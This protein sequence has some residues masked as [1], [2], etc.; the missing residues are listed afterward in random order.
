MGNLDRVRELGYPD[1]FIRLW[2]YYLCYCEGGFAERQ[3]GDVQ[4]LLTKPDCRLTA[5]GVERS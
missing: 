5:V 3:L 1:S 4:L 2:E